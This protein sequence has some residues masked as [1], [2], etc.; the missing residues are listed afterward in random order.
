[1]A[2]SS[3]APLALFRSATARAA[4]ITAAGMPFKR[5]KVIKKHVAIK[6]EPSSVAVEGVRQPAIE[7]DIKAYK[8]RVTPKDALGNYLGPGHA[9]SVQL[10][11]STGKWTE[12]LQDHLDG[13][14]TQVLA[15]P[16]GAI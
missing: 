14:Y 8:V 13:T 9:G 10:A 5:E 16:K 7:Q 6:V 11:A 12:S 15:I 3:S 4:G 1:M 2:L